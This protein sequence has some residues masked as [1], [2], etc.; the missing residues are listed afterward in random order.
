MKGFIKKVAQ[1]FGHDIVHLP[2]DPI[3]RQWLD[4]MRSNNIEMVFDV[5]ANTG[6]FGKKI[7]SF[8]YTGSIVSFEPLSDAYD[9]LQLTAQNDQAWQAVRSGIGHYDGIAEIN[10]S[11]NSYSSSLLD[12]L[13]LH[14]DSEVDAVYVRKET[15]IMLKIDSVINQYSRPG[16]N[17][18]V[19]IDAQGFERQVFEG[20]SQSFDRIK[21]FQVEL[22]I[23]QLYEQ[24]TLM[25]EMID[26]LRQAG[27]KLKLIEGGHRNYETGELLQVE[28]YFFK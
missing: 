17:I 27:Y 28:G 21:G 8:G 4:L 23:Q 14:V 2:S 9:Q 24:E 15:I 7:R 10:V 12:I 25:A 22:S 3:V 19:K 1:R 6:Q 26:L 11:R 20:C 18:Y 13:P 5:G 16:Q